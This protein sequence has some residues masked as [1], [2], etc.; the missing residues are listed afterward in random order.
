MR[1]SASWRSYAMRFLTIASTVIGCLLIGAGQCDADIVPGLN[2]LADAGF[3]D[4]TPEDNKFEVWTD[5]LISPGAWY[6]EKHF[7]SLYETYAAPGAKRS[8]EMG[9]YFNYAHNAT[10]ARLAQR[11][12]LSDYLADISAGTVTATFT[13]YFN[14]DAAA[15]DNQFLVGLATY[16][17]DPSVRVWH[18][19]DLFADT[20]PG[21]EQLTLSIDLPADTE[22]LFV[23]VS[24]LDANGENSFAGNYGDDFSLTLSDVPEPSTVAGLIGMGCVGLLLAWR[25]RRRPRRHLARIQEDGGRP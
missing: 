9:V 18:W 19:E 22:G 21:W 2:L 13:G 20:L 8:G 15:P 4:H 7:T 1:G 11:V 10:E 17:E 12:V 16:A 23:R 24:A 14:R 3:E 25:K 6:T 5:P